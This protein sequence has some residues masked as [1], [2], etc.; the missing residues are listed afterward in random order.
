MSISVKL[1]L[2]PRIAWAAVI[3]FTA[4]A[5][6]CGDD[7]RVVPFQS[8]TTAVNPGDKLAEPFGIAVKGDEIYFSDGNSGTIYRYS[9]AAGLSE[10]AAGFETPSGIAFDNEGSLLVADTGSHTIKRIDTA[11]NTTVIA[12]TEGVSGNADGAAAVAQFNA[13][14]GIAAADDGRVFVSDT[15][16]DRI[17]VIA[18]GQVTTIAGGEKGFTD[19]VA[20]SAMFETPLGIASWHGDKLLVA[21]SGNRR[22]RVVEPD[23]RVWTLSGNGGGGLRDGTLGTASFVSPT[24]VAVDDVGSIYIADGN[25]IRAIGL[26]PLP[27]LE[28]L[29]GGKRGFRN[30][31]PHAAEYN[32]PS[33]LAVGS[34]GELY[35]ADSDNALVRKIGRMA[36]GL[37]ERNAVQQKPPRF[38]ADEFRNLQPGRWPYDPADRP[39]EIAGTL[40]EI[41]G[42]IV[43]ETSQ[44]WFHNGLDIPGDYGEK[45]RF[46]RDEKV[47]D[48]EAV[49]NFATSRE[50]IRMPTIGYVHINIG[51]DSRGNPFDDNRFQFYSSGGKP[52]GVRV[53]RGTKFRAGEPIGTLNSQNHVHLVAGRSGAEM[54]AL[55][56]LALPGIS[57][58]IAP[59]IENVALFDE[60][61]TPVETKNASGR[62][63]LSGK[64]RIVVRA[65]DRKDGNPDRR[66][67]APYEIGYVLISEGDGPKAPATWNIS[68]EKMPPPSAVKYTYA[69]GSRSGATGVTVFNF[70]ATNFVDGDR[71]REGFI[72]AADIS[73]GEYTLRVFAADFF[74]NIASQDILIEAIK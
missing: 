25:V 12:G 4:V 62:I 27:F 67:L 73:P 38:T 3:A 58:G 10:F 55:D 6:G 5:F 29:S 56:A 34:G 60:S 9:P 28:T 54:N 33:G 53:A 66:R 49:Q 40:G 51:R 68:F 65:F 7:R 19:G 59:V 14:I 50:L 70:I 13:P 16:N 41:R 39:R 18:N 71:Y 45:A 2:R 46:I 74:G 22:V 17:R 35:I 23:G 26:R 61:W 15:Y 47:L 72:D 32:R 37:A 42:A 57:D 52:A 69:I 8:V 43:D 11:G 21:D 31:V 20:D 30:G 1:S 64:T 36:D 48:P 63:I 44:A 24:A